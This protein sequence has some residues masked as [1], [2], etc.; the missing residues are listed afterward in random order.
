MALIAAR[1]ASG[2]TQAQ[3]AKESGINTRLYQ[4]YETGNKKPSVDNAIRI[5]DSLG[6]TDLRE[7]FAPAPNQHTTHQPEQ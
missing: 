7:L 3:V 6:V 1:K 4:Y 2:K 5:A